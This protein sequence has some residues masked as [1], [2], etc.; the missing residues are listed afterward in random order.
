MIR[1]MHFS[2]EIL[3]V[4]SVYPKYF[5]MQPLSLSKGEDSGESLNK[6]KVFE[7]IKSFLTSLS[8][9]FPNIH[10]VYLSHN[11]NLAD[12]LIG[13]LELVYG[14]AV[15]HETLLGLTFDIGPQSFFQTNS[16]GAEILY[17]LVKNFAHSET[18]QSG[19]VLDLYAGTGTI[20]MIFSDIA[21]EVVSVELVKEASESGARNATK[22]GIT[23]MKFVNA[24][25]EEFLE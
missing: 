10:S 19:R 23:N 20:G 8:P 6:E 1:K 7:D 12:T 13:D 11:G 22:N 4:L 17:S 15:I 25:V 14:E 21:Q 24:K 9:E 5:D 18:F 2:G 3:I 16:Q